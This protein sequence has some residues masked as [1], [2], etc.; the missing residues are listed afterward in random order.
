MEANITKVQITE[1]EGKKYN[2][3]VKSTAEFDAFA[4]FEPITNLTAEEAVRTLIELN[5]KKSLSAGIGINIPDDFIF[6][7]PDGNG[8]I[9]FMKTND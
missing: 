9:I 4:D 8:A 6:D 3:F 1:D 2:F 7:D 5:I